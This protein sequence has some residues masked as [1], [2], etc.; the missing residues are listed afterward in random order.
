MKEPDAEKMFINVLGGKKG[1]PSL[2]V[3]RGELKELGIATELTK[4]P[5]VCRTK[6]KTKGG[7][8]DSK[9]GTRNRCKYPRHTP[10]FTDRST[11]RTRD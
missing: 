9:C 2:E 11:R 6:G 7:G 8:Q 1:D 10:F 5:L 4:G 3:A